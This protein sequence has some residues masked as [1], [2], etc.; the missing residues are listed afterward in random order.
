[1]D[2][3]AVNV[4]GV[5]GA[6]TAIEAA[7]GKIRPSLA[8]EDEL[9]VEVPSLHENAMKGIAA[10]FGKTKFQILING[11]RTDVATPVMRTM[12]GKV[13]HNPVTSPIVTTLAAALL[14]A[15]LSAGLYYVRNA[16]QNQKAPKGVTGQQAPTQPHSHR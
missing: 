15:S 14:A 11:Q 2:L 13:R 6:R 1:M 7:G 3:Y 9:H 5:K 10:G 4:R 16:V 12:V 8:P